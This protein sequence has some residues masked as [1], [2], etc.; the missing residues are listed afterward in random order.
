[1]RALSVD[2][3]WV[4]CYVEDISIGESISEPSEV[5]I[6]I[7]EITTETF[8]FE[9]PD[10]WDESEYAIVRLVQYIERVNQPILHI[11]IENTTVSIKIPT[12]DT[13][14]KPSYSPDSETYTIPN[15]QKIRYGTL[16]FSGIL[17]LAAL[18]VFQM[19]IGLVAGVT[20]NSKEYTFF[21]IFGFPVGFL[22]MFLG[23]FFSYEVLFGDT[24]GN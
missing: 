13:I 17:G 6:T 15:L 24:Y 23:T 8:Q 16:V 12:T 5:V 4:E 20:P 18:S 11:S 2:S 22:L 9:T 1:L 10:V 21:M 19:D 3:D 14:L 7:P